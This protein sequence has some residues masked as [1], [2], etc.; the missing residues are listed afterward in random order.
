MTEGKE[1]SYPGHKH[2]ATETNTRTVFNIC[3]VGPY[4]VCELRLT[5]DSAD[6]ETPNEASP[7]EPLSLLDND[8]Q[9]RTV[10]VQDMTAMS[11]QNHL[12]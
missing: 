10:P 1:K 8:Y 2:R 9:V 11:N 12:G 3:F 5:V 6:G 7:T 4:S